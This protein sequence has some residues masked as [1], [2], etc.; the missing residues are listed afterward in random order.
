MY[1]FS[2]SIGH[3]IFDEKG[4]CVEEI[5]CEQTPTINNTQ[6]EKREKKYKTLAPL[7]KQK[8]DIALT[9]LRDKRY[10]AL[11]RR[12][13]L[14]QSAQNLKESVGPDALIVQ[15]VSTIEELDKVTNLLTKRL[16]EW[17]ALTLPEI[18]EQITDH[19]HFA[20][21]V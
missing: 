3:F 8:I 12:A 9:H 14:Q 17:H 6:L 15:T 18:G 2:N 7:P 16:R 5:L 1:L 11:L 20:Q 21:L 13:N 19:Q 4:N 10:I